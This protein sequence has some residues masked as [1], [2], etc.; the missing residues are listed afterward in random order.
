V[1]LL[2]R[3]RTSKAH[4]IAS[5]P[6]PRRA[7]PLRDARR[8][9]RARCRGPLRARRPSEGPPSWRR[10]F[11]CETGSTST[12]LL[13]HVPAGPSGKVS[14]ARRALAAPAVVNDGVELCACCIVPDSRR[15][16]RGF[17]FQPGVARSA[18]E[19]SLQDAA[20]GVQAAHAS[21]ARALDGYRDRPWMRPSH[22]ST[23]RGGAPYHRRH[24]ESAASQQRAGPDRTGYCTRA[25]GV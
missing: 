6:R 8:R 5:R 1:R 12:R 24:R 14:T 21:S 18:L 22:S 16:R 17:M 2:E 7:R 10:H 3:R 23:R 4:V 25:G 11:L 9:R 13:G 15:R 19:K 20:R